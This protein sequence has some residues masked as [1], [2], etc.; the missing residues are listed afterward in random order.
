ML[1][2]VLY[3]SVQQRWQSEFVMERISNF[4]STDSSGATYVDV[5]TRVSHTH[6]HQI[7]IGNPMAVGMKPLSFYR[8]VIS[9]SISGEEDERL[10]EDVRRRVQEIRDQFPLGAYTDSVGSP[11]VRQMV[12]DFLEKR[13]GA[14]TSLDDIIMSN[15][16]SEA[17]SLLMNTIIR[18]G[19]EVMIPIPQY[20]LYSANITLV[21]ATRKNY[22]LNEDDNWSFDVESCELSE[23]TRVFVAINPGNPTG[24]CLPESSILEILR[25][26]ERDAPNCIVVADEVYQDNIWNES[27]PF[28]SFRKVA[29]EYD[30]NVS[31]HSNNNNNNSQGE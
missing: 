24:S 23:R 19:D 7:Q 17:A 27:R 18:E 30:L 10:P 21:G 29:T 22:F 16:A 9:S 26:I 8:N 13:D 4:P 6:T 25:K 15:G 28:V 11:Y 1:F 3:L 14:K 20:P 5:S 12:A 31:H 2:A